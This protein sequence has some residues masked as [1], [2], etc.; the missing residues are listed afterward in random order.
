MFQI[1]NRCSDAHDDSA[2][3]K[4]KVNERTHKIKKTHSSFEP[5]LLQKITKK[6][7]GIIDENSRIFSAT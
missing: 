4:S 3:N 7:M 2:R 5:F 1:R 6:T